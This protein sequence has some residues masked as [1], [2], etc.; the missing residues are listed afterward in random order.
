M[1]SLDVGA[2]GTFL[3]NVI[4]GWDPATTQNTAALFKAQDLQVAKY[5]SGFAM[6][7]RMG[8]CS[9]TLG[10]KNLYSKYT[11]YVNSDKTSGYSGTS[12]S[13]TITASANF[14][15]G[16][17][18]LMYS[19][20]YYSIVPNSTNTT[21]STSAKGITKWSTITANIASGNYMDYT[22]QVSWTNNYYGYVWMYSYKGSNKYTGNRQ[23]WVNT[24]T[25]YGKYIMEC[26]GASGGKSILDGKM[27]DTGGRGGYTYGEIVIESKSWYIF[28]GGQG[29]DNS[30]NS[31]TG[32]SG[33]ANGGWNGGGLGKSDGCDD[34]G[35]SG[36]GGAT[37]IRTRISSGQAVTTWKDLYSLKSRIMVAGGGGG[38]ACS[39]NNGGC[40]GNATGGKGWWDESG[41][42]TYNTSTGHNPGTQTGGYRFGYGQDGANGTGS[43][44]SDNSNITNAGGGGGYYGGAN[45]S[46]YRIHINP[47]QSSPGGSSYISG[48][49]GCNTIN[50][51][52]SVWT[53]GASNHSGS[54]NHYTGNVFTNTQMINGLNEMPAPYGGTETG[55]YGN[56]YVRITFVPI[57]D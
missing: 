15:D 11:N 31:S 20:K 38:G 10:T 26:W 43:T 14:A 57:E 36:G 2:L 32:R 21:F 40:G 1:Y 22:A 50:E 35:S 37:D 18:L 51:N 19:G 52:C 45:S 9:I 3:A 30:Y 25:G 55:H 54:P 4:S 5:N 7:H 56:G 48:H 13:K 28:V 8:L 44:S 53:G 47:G 24:N 27:Y 16:K 33:D 39:L 49:S 23:E 29:Q 42:M 6:S 17:S 34:D 41:T 12:T 46:P